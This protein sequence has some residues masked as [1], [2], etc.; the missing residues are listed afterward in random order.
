VAPWRPSA[1]WRS[2]VATGSEVVEG[3][4]LRVPTA[5]DYSQLS[6]HALRLM[7]ETQAEGNAKYGYG[8]WQKG[9]PL[10]NL[11]S[12]AIEHILK[13][14]NGDVSENHLGHA[15]WN[16]EKAAH[17]VV[18][19]PDLVDIIPL[20]KALGLDGDMGCAHKFVNIDTHS[21]KQD[22]CTKC[23]YTVERRDR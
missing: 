4:A 6:Q 8:N 22:M 10:S 17:F 7:A 1:D 13:F 18:E 11:M 2:F 20:R 15:L 23:G 14:V 16:L 9:L 12:H 19:R 21:D 3:G 5:T